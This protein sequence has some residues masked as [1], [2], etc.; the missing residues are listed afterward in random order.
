MEFQPHQVEALNSETGQTEFIPNELV[1]QAVQSG[2]YQFDPEDRVKVFNEFGAPKTLKI[3]ALP[4]AIQSGYRAATA[5][6]QKE[7]YLQKNYGDNTIEAAAEGAARGLSLGLSDYALKGLGVPEERLK[8]VKERNKAAAYT[9][10]IG[11]ILGTALIPAAAVGK[12]AQAGK[13]L[14]IL[15]RL[16]GEAGTIAEKK[17]AEKLLAGTLSEVAAGTASKTL[18]KKIVETYAPT[19]ASG[20]VQGAAYS[21]GNLISEDALGN[22]DLNAEN[23]VSAIGLGALFGGATSVALKGVSQGLSRFIKKAPEP[24]EAP[25]ATASTPIEEPGASA[26]MASSSAEST[27]TASTSNDAT[28][29][30]KISQES[31]DLGRFLKKDP[32]DL[33][34]WKLNAKRAEA[35]PRL[36]TELDPSSGSD[37]LEDVVRRS[38]EE[39]GPRIK[40][41]AEKSN[42]IIEDSGL[43]KS[44]SEVADIIKNRLNKLKSIKTKGSETKKAI[45]SLRDFL[46]QISDKYDGDGVLISKAPESLG[47][48]DIKSFISELDNDLEGFYSRKLGSKATTQTEKALIGLRA[49]VS[50][51]L[52]KDLKSLGYGEYSDLMNEQKNLI[53]IRDRFEKNFSANNSY[54]QRFLKTL[55]RNEAGFQS[56]K[57]LT[58]RGLKESDSW[59]KTIDDLGKA[60]DV[61][62][63]T[64]YK[65]RAVRARLFPNLA[66]GA[67]RGSVMGNL[68]RIGWDVA[69]YGMNPA[70]FAKDLVVEHSLNIGSKSTLM[71]KLKQ[72][73]LFEIFSENPTFKARVVSN[74]SR[75]ASVTANQTK[76]LSDVIDRALIP[77]AAKAASTTSQNIFGKFST[78][79][80]DR[81]KN[82][83]EYF[84]KLSEQ[85]TNLSTDPNAMN[86]KLNEHTAGMDEYLPNTKQA[87][88]N[89]MAKGVKYLTD[90][91]PKNPI[92]GEEIIKNEWVPSD[93]ELSAWKRRIEAV[94][95]PIKAIEDVAN[96]VGSHEAVE[97]IKEVYPNIYQEAV[98]QLI[99]KIADNKKEIPYQK[100]LQLSMLTGAPLDYSVNPEFVGKMQG[101]FKKPE[102]ST[103]QGQ[104][105]SGDLYKN[106]LSRSQELG[107]R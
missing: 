29:K 52:K 49:D 15:P 69:K 34:Y 28:S 33:E 98:R 19:M 7:Y 86:Y 107:A 88:Q 55:E 87:M 47:A 74:L 71:N 12:V 62:F 32:K 1:P 14:G 36:G 41:S 64:I 24:V 40:E 77:V 101:M 35:Q 4:S 53:G 17:V 43:I 65:D 44:T 26:G 81:P 30:I 22:K 45:E 80:S 9:G 20:A 85:L 84:D 100:R 42:K 73:A 21:V 104:P 67:E 93:S 5:D 83:K 51:S 10:E 56:G 82:K 94:D 95:N 96:G 90:T 8:E 25:N 106:T 63:R 31:K 99:S 59:M 75:V 72:D 50:E 60:T 27:S 66:E 18:A 79:T 48:Q 57:A 70:G 102:P 46:D 11:S 37:S 2:K 78:E 103:P 61:D 13:A 68:A 23:I 3:G 58:K 105:M 38:Y 92:I 6:E 76:R 91:Q 39:L 97:A 16:I 89:I 54:S